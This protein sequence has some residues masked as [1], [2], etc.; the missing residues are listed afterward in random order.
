MDGGG[1]SPSKT[2]LRHQ[3]INSVIFVPENDVSSF[4]PFFMLSKRYHARTRADPEPCT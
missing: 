3:L 4:V 1:V 2:L